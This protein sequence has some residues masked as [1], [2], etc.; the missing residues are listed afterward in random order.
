MIRLTS[1]AAD[2]APAPAAAITLVVVADNP[3]VALGVAALLRRA[4]LEKIGSVIVPNGP[5][6]SSGS[7]STLTKRQPIGETITV[8]L[9]DRGVGAGPALQLVRSGTPVV[10]V[11]TPTQRAHDLSIALSRGVMWFVDPDDGIRA[12]QTAVAA[13]AEGAAGW[14][15]QQLLRV[16]GT[17]PF[18]ANHRET[19]I[20][21]R[22]RELIQ[23]MK[24]GAGNKSIALDLG[25]TPKTVESLQRILYR[26]L[27]ARNREQA[28][29]RFRE[30]PGAE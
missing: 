10:L 19:R 15:A 12:L 22:E 2:A 28:L 27:G 1:V 20:T 21:A 6:R 4:N 7:T 29:Q 30:L 17:S 13:L 11:T 24:S 9:D 14:N 16:V 23:L 5:R 26:K 8:V 3:L 25:V 18:P